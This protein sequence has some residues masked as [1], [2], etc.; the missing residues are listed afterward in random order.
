[1]L[2]SRPSGVKTEEIALPSPDQRIHAGDF[3][4]LVGREDRIKQLHDLGLDIYPEPNNG[5]LTPQGVSFAEVILA[6]HS[7]SEGHT[8]KDIDFRRRFGLTAVALLRPDRS[9]RTNVGDFRLVLGDSLLVIGTKPQL[10]ALARSADF[11]VIEPNPSDQPVDWKQAGLSIGIILAAIVASIAGAPVYLCMLVG[12]LLTVLTRLLTLE[13]VYQSIEWQ[14]IFLV[15]G[16]YAVSIAMVQTGLADRLG[17]G[18]I[19]LVTPLGPLGVA[20]GAYVLTSLLTQFMGGQ[21]T[22]LVTGP[23]TISAALHMGVNR[24]RWQ[25][26][27]PS[28]ARLPSLRDGASGQHPHDRPGELYLQGFSSSG[29]AINGGLFCDADGGVVDL[30]RL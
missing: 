8:L 7:K 4:V 21:V 23:V 2:V 29:L 9:Y 24:K 17:H 14:A 28:G 3:L 30:W 5:H 25:S 26:P 11:I 13:E 16:M 6:P 15:A 1:V 18:M 27:R 22:A 20:A 10:K 19:R 12:A